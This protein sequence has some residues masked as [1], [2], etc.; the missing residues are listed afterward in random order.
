MTWKSDDVNKLYELKQAGS[1]WKQIGIALGRSPAAV[2]KF[3]QRN[4]CVATLPPRIVSRN[5][6]TDGR[7][8]LAI[9]RIVQTT[10]TVKISDIPAMLRDEGASPS[11]VP[12]RQT[13]GK[14]LGQNGFEVKTAYK[15]PMIS[16]RNQLKRVDFADRWL[17]IGPEGLH[18]VIWSDETTVRSMPTSKDLQIIVHNSIPRDARPI[19]PQIQGG[20]ISVMFWGSFSRLGVGPLVAVDGT[21]NASTYIEILSEYLIPEIRT[22]KNDYGVD[23]VFMQDN[24]P[25]HKAHSVMDFLASNGVETIDWPPQSPDLN[26]IE[27]LWAIVKSRRAKKFGVPTNRND[28]IEQIFEIWD[29]LEPELITNLIESIPNRLKLCSKG[30]G[31]ATKY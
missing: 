6:K 2:R 25:C 23:L 18:N 17:N 30:K 7:I 19:N 22:A 24:A 5:R 12:S 21:M 1:T 10:P 29:G 13:I 15:K 4:Q 14:F 27:N 8:G 26:P 11:R 16:T 3:H 9:K 20:G 31:K 28:L